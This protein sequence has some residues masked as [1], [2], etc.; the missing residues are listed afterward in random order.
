MAGYWIVDPDSRTLQVH[1]LENGRFFTRSY[2]EAGSVPLHVLQGCE[3][4]LPDVFGA[5]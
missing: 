3:I 5:D 1:I 4:S 2:D